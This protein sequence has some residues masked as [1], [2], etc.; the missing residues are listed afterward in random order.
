MSA[1]A[2][3]ELRRL[4]S[5]VTT[6]A[7]GVSASSASHTLRALENRRLVT[8][9]RRGLWSV[10]TT[11]PD[12]RALAADITRPYPSYVSFE[13]ALFAHGMID[14]VPR[15]ITLASLGRPRTAEVRRLPEFVSLTADLWESLKPEWQE[16]RETVQRG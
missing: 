15:A 16:A 11:I 7:L 4:G 3:S 10:D 2:Y 1:R 8:R 13:S 12:A 6:A 5:T 9:V 14:Q